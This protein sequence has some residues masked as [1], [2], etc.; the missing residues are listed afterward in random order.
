[1]WTVYGIPGIL[2]S[3]VRA[4]SIRRFFGSLLLGTLLRLEQHACPDSSPALPA[5]GQSFVRAEALRLEGVGA[6]EELLL[7]VPNPRN[8]CH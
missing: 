4:G 8:P 6:P 1:M 5:R 7:L 3:V 2:A